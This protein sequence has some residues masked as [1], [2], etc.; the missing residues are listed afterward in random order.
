MSI[1][2]PRLGSIPRTPRFTTKPPKACGALFCPIRPPPKAGHSPPPP[3]TVSRS[4][5]YR[6]QLV[7]PTFWHRA[8]RAPRP[9]T[10]SRARPHRCFASAWPILVQWP[11]TRSTCMPKPP[12]LMLC[13]WASKRSEPTTW[14]RAKSR[15]KW[16]TRWRVSPWGK[17]HWPLWQALPVTPCSPSRCPAR[18]NQENL[19]H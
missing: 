6:V 15:S 19:P 14:S 8:T 4:P 12:A 16:A 9:V 13:W 10:T 3:P 5:C 18:S 7:R 11:T 2:P 1:L 17:A